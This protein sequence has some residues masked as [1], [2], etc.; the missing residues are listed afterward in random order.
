MPAKPR[1]HPYYTPA[2]L[3]QQ[4]LLG[5]QL[6]DGS[7]GGNYGQGGGK[8]GDPY[9]PAKGGGKDDGDGH[10]YKGDINFVKGG[11]K[12]QKSDGH[13]HKGGG[14]GQKHKSRPKMGFP[15]T[16]D[17]T[18]EFLSCPRCGMGMVYHMRGKMQLDAR[19]LALPPPN[20]KGREIWRKY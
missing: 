13:E 15:A 5:Q 9:G 4:P 17:F 10:D 18:P 8:G 7:G 16:I 11:D 20:G 2:P 12:G 1:G 6:R 19:V 3:G 14:K